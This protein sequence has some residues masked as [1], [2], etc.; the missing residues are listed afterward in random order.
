MHIM[1]LGNRDTQVIW[2][3]RHQSGM[4]CSNQSLFPLLLGEFSTLASI[5]QQYLNYI[6]FQNITS[7]ICCTWSV[8]LESVKPFLWSDL[9][10]LFGHYH[11]KELVVPCNNKCTHTIK[12]QLVSSRNIT[13]KQ[14]SIVVCFIRL[15]YCKF[16]CLIYN[17]MYLKI[18]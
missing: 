11:V 13:I 14:A 16:V 17:S 15:I 18:F 1:V 7:L 8:I 4:Y 2:E 10:W 3:E 9:V 6:Y 12:Y 5:C